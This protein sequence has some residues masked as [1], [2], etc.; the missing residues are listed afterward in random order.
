M[1]GGKQ[2]QSGTSHAAAPFHDTAQL[3]VQEDAVLRQKRTVRHTGQKQTER[4]VKHR[5]R[6]R[7][8]ERN[9]GQREDN[10][11]SRTETG[12]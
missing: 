10:Q 3:W 6:W 7:G 2:A 5:E 11:R 9:T 12:K 1:P 8:M 4:T